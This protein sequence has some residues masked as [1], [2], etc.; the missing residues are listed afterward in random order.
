MGEDEEMNDS[1]ELALSNPLTQ[2]EWDELTDVELE[3]A[4]KI[5]FGTPSGKRI[6]FVPVSVLE[7]IRA[8]IEDLEPEFNFEGFYKCQSQALDIIDKHLKGE[9]NDG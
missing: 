9:G 5:W 1:F 6:E 3:R 8:E 7:D 4:Q 2:E